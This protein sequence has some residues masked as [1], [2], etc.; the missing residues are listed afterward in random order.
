VLS[1]VKVLENIEG[2]GRNSGQVDDRGRVLARPVAGRQH[3]DT[4]IGQLSEWL[5]RVELTVEVTKLFFP[6]PSVNDAESNLSLKSI[7]SQV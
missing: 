5:R 3:P 7:S 2:G 1:Q 4:E 6:W